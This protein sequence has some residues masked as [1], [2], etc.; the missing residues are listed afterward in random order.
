[1]STTKPYKY[2]PLAPGEI[3]LLQ[4]LPAIT[5]DVHNDPIQLNI[6]HATVSGSTAPA[7][8]S[9]YEALSYV[10][11][12]ERTET[13]Y[14]DG[15]EI[16][17]TPNLVSAL[18]RLRHH[19][20]NL[21]LQRALWVDSICVNQDDTAERGHQVR[22][23]RDIYSHATR[24]LIWLGDHTSVTEKLRRF[25]YGYL[26]YYTSD[27]ETDNRS[28]RTRSKSVQEIWG[29]P[30]F[31]RVWVIQEVVF[32]PKGL[33][34]SGEEYVDWEQLV[35]A[36]TWTRAAGDTVDD[37]RRS[38]S[39]AVLGIES[40]RTYIMRTTKL[41]N[42]RRGMGPSVSS[43]KDL[44]QLAH[45]FRSYSSTDP[46]DKIYAFIGLASALSWDRLASR[47][48]PDYDR[49]VEDVFFNF[50]RHVLE[51][52][53]PLRL[54]QYLDGCRPQSS[55]LPSWVP[56]WRIPLK[57]PP[58][59]H[60]LKPQFLLSDKGDFGQ[61]LPEQPDPHIL[62]LQGVHVD[63]VDGLTDVGKAGVWNIS[64]N[65]GQIRKVSFDSGS[66]EDTSANFIDWTMFTVKDPAEIY[67]GR[68]FM[69]TRKRVYGLCPAEACIGDEIVWFPGAQTLFL[70]RR[71]DNGDAVIVGDCHLRKDMLG[72][73]LGDD[74]NKSSYYRLR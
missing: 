32:A 12:G 40:L 50:A 15:C 8:F 13:V 69:V 9:E 11:G 74:L 28:L 14:C 4:L 33:V 20:K 71:Q 55:K 30:W 38:R 25:K 19:A 16:K 26:P 42:N 65:V 72:L 66:D 7:T 73:I 62:T 58:L 10:W 45:L 34:M 22:L 35:T 44:L 5:P 53:Y 17:A 46:R 37:W 18:W 70:L 68:R 48:D 47:I 67:S 56:D 3:R 43:P 6:V 51:T 63:H 1:M 59:A 52:P 64:L 31:E 61:E 60:V 39:A 57:A 41:Q 36:A 21:S 23:M 27:G 29:A 2:R 54:L 24:V 49:S